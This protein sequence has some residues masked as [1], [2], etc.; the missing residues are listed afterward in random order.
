MLLLSGIISSQFFSL[1]ILKILALH[2]LSSLCLWPVY[3]IPC[4]YFLAIQKDDLMALSTQCS[5]DWSR[6]G[7]RYIHVW[8]STLVKYLNFLLPSRS[9]CKGT[10]L[11]LSLFCHILEKYIARL[12]IYMLHINLTNQDIIWFST[13][14]RFVVRIYI[15]YLIHVLVLLFRGV[16]TDMLNSCTA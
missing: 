16:L 1:L 9:N 6:Q 10:S 13:T 7:R 11:S 12:L 8:I 4:F 2:F 5:I 3:F 15:L 14:E